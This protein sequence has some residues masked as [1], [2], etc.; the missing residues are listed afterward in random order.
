MTSDAQ[1]A[2]ASAAA[3]PLVPLPSRRLV[4]G[5]LFSRFLS[6]GP[7]V[8]SP[9][10][11]E[12]AILS[13]LW[14]SSLR[15]SRRETGQPFD[16]R[17]IPA[18]E[19]AASC[20][21][22]VPRWHSLPTLVR[23]HQRLGQ[24]LAIDIV[25]QGEVLDYAN[26]LWSLITSAQGVVASE[27]HRWTRE[28]AGIA[29]E[30][31]WYGPSLH[32]E[33]QLLLAQ[34]RDAQGSTGA[35]I[36]SLLFRAS[37]QHLVV[38][39]LSGARE[40]IGLATTAPPGV[41]VM[42]DESTPAAYGGWGKAGSKAKLFVD[43]LTRPPAEIHGRPVV[44]VYSL[45]LEVAVIA[46]RVE[47]AAEDARRRVLRLLDVVSAAHPSARLRLSEL[48]G[49][50][51]PDSG[52]FH[53]HSFAGHVARSIE[54]DPHLP[55]SS[56]A[57]SIR[58]AA[59]I[60]QLADPLTRASFSWIAFETAGLKSGS[61]SAC[62]RSLALVCVRHLAIVAFR[63][64]QRGVTEIGDTQRS[65]DLKAR[66][67][68]RKARKLRKASPRNKE[69]VEGLV[70]RAISHEAAASEYETRAAEL[71]ASY[72][73]AVERIDQL[74]VSAPNLSFGQKGFANLVDMSGWQ[75][76]LKELVSS[77]VPAPLSE[78]IA[79][80]PDW[81]TVSI[82]SCATLFADPLA[83]ARELESSAAYFGK[84]V[85]GLY[86]ARNVHLHSGLSDVPGSS[87]IGAVAPLLI[88]TMTE[89]F[90]HWQSEGSAAGPLDVV[91]QLSTRFE[92]VLASGPSAFDTS[93]LT[94]P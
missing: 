91:A 44:P 88:D 84:L 54:L 26:E 8:E 30:L 35:Q 25:E 22:S 45:L 71:L 15:R 73:F 55:P 50:G 79:V 92:T 4:F 29:Q 42:Q 94:S 86:S 27:L 41:R 74:G 16:S 89:L 48:V 78:L 93:T 67:E 10:G 18:R 64:V 43:A 62:G 2:T 69:L 7:L 38:I 59:L 66:S 23:W 12:S 19:S 52:A 3:E 46:P 63:D 6:P 58:A 70:A 68:R 61:A 81:A 49:V 90:L 60:R 11:S 28:L 53:V 36:D 83:M 77:D 14:A 9:F 51:H 65:Y 20:I 40:I 17:L 87:A 75:R 24:G 72:A 39:G 32:S 57:S 76:Q 13:T 82:R 5:R 34:E 47:T 80:L 37:T 85:D 56:L 31:E 33:L 1:G 21:Q